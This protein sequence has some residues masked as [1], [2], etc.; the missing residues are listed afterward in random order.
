MAS[1]IFSCSSENTKQLSF[2]DDIAYICIYIKR[3]IVFGF[4]FRTRNINLFFKLY[5]LIFNTLGNM[6]FGLTEKIKN[7][8]LCK[9]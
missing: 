7:I 9:M 3:V 4:G 1:M 6:G 5:L 8:N 2:P